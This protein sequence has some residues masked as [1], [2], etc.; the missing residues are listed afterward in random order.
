MKPPSMT[1]PSATMT[2]ESP[3]LAAFFRPELGEVLPALGSTAGGRGEAAMPAGPAVEHKDEPHGTEGGTDADKEGELAAR[4]GS[5]P[6]LRR[7]RVRRHLQA[8]FDHGQ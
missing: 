8:I 7:R 5:R 3:L 1:R 6:D 2:Q 4:R